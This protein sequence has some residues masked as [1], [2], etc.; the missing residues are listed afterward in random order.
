MPKIACYLM[1][2][3]YHPG[4][5]YWNKDEFN[6]RRDLNAINFLLNTEGLELHVMP[7]TV[8]RVY[9]FDQDETMAR[10]QGQG[11]IWD[12]LAARWLTHAPQVK[13]WVMWD[14]AL[15]EAMIH[16]ALAEEGTFNTPPENRQRKVHVYTKIDVPGM[17]ADWWK[18]TKL[19]GG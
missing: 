8:C 12:Y 11:G 6:F 9:R 17:L 13:K 2:G 18:A 3:H 14:V 10:L 5:D 15:I 4:G 16:P 7:A 19:P 1:G